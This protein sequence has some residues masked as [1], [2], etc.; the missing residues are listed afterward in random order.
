[1]RR[2]FALILFI[3]AFVPSQAWAEEP[4]NTVLGFSPTDCGSHDDCEQRLTQHVRNLFPS[5]TA[6]RD[7]I[8]R[9]TAEHF[10]RIRSEEQYAD[11]KKIAKYS[12]V[13]NYLLLRQNSDQD[14]VINWHKDEDS[15]KPQGQVGEVSVK[16][17]RYRGNGW[18]PKISP[19]IVQNLKSSDPKA[20]P[21]DPWYSETLYA[22]LNKRLKSRYPLGSSAERLRADLLAQGFFEVSVQ[23]DNIIKHSMLYYITI[24]GT[25]YEEWRQ[26][27]TLDPGAWSYWRIEWTEDSKEMITTLGGAYKIVFQ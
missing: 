11:G 7:V 4:V 27:K 26:H 24:G 13:K 9:L 6:E 1:M 15:I 19:E 23:R 2:W 12:V 16:L 25:P 17:R 10:E 20:T 18:E 3:L 22:D 21:K 14:V 8:E 5:G